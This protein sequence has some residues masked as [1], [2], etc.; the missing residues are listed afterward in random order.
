MSDRKA[1]RVSVYSNL[2]QPDVLLT[3]PESRR[4]QAP[5]VRLMI[6]I[7]EDAILCFQR[8]RNAKDG[9]TRR[10]FREAHDWLMSD[11]KEWTFSFQSICEVLGLS[12]SYVRRGLEQW[13]D[14]TPSRM[15]SGTAG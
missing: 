2:F 11:D 13:T 14:D 3:M 12:P 1:V 6:R 15:S 7:L 5:E 9:P 10:S 4:Q 8:Y